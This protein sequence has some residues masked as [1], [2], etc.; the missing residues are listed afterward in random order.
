MYFDH[1]SYSVF[2]SQ[3]HR[4]FISHML[5]YCVSYDGGRYDTATTAEILFDEKHVSRYYG[6]NDDDNE[7]DEYSGGKADDGV[8]EN[9]RE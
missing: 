1:V 6:D 4:Q 8:S 2:T 7:D 3:Q 5:V 9:E